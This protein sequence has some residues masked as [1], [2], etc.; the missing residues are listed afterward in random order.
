MNRLTM[1]AVLGGATVFFFDPQQGEGRRR[2]VQ[3]FWRENRD[4]AVEIGGGVSQA[5]GSIRPLVRRVKGGLE[6][7]D[8]ADNGGSSWMPKVTKG[9]ILAAALGG[10]VAYFLHPQ[11]GLVRRQRVLSFLGEQQDA[12]KAG[13]GSVQKAVKTDEAK[14]V[15]YVGTNGRR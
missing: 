13:F 11:D 9:F 15:E 3:S 6:R 8:W 1:G 14:A 5:A 7:G 10:A 2:R 12:V 4:T